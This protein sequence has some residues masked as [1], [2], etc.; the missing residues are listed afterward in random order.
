[1]NKSEHVGG[2]L[3][4]SSSQRFDMSGGFV[5]WGVKLNKFENV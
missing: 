3:Y 4:S 2:V 1:M 5:E